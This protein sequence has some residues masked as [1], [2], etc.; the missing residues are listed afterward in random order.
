MNAIA[1]FLSLG[2]H[3]ADRR[4]AAVLAR[5]SLEPA[6]RY[7]KG[8][9][10]VTTVDRVTRYLRSVMSSSETWR[11]ASSLHD[12]WT[13]AEWPARYRTIGL[14]LLIAVGVHVAAT[15]MRGPRPGWF[16]LIVPAMVSAFALILL[17]VSRSTRPPN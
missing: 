8:S 1:R 15:V 16:W 10:V 5:P 3:D 2:L 17:M 7:L 4:V 11:A 12:A 13:R 9:A 14:M 6:D